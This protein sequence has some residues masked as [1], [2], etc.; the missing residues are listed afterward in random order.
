MT[1]MIGGTREFP[2]HY[3]DQRLGD[4]DEPNV[5]EWLAE[6]GADQGFRLVRARRACM[7]T[8]LVLSL[9]LAMCGL[10]WYLPAMASGLA[11]L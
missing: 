8:P 1:C 4:Q 7:R 2:V 10:T 3:G 11:R 9:N 6:L 5:L